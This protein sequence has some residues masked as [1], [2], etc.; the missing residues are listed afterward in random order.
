M[1][2]LDKKETWLQKELYE[3]R[4]FR[5]SGLCHIAEAINEINEINTNVGY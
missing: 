5:Y 3:L 4:N 2:K 1:L